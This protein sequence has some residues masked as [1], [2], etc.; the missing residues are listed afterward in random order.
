MRDFRL[1]LNPVKDRM[2]NWLENE[3]EAIIFEQDGVLV[4]YALYRH[5]PNSI[6]LRH[7]FVGRRHRR[8]GIGRQAIQI[9]L[10]QVWPPGRRVTL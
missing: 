9:L 7:F 8:E 5:D 2:R 6:Y 10:S 3:Y 4:A 1:V